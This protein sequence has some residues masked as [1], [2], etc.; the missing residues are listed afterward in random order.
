VNDRAAGPCTALWSHPSVTSSPRIRI[1]GIGTVIVFNRTDCCTDRLSDFDVSA[2][3][4]ST[5]QP[6]GGITGPAQPRNVF[7]TSVSSRF[8]RVQL[9]GSNYLSLADVQVYV[10]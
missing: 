6:I 2:W 10:P 5:W 1:P 8:I 3:D 7:Q 4:G 9:R